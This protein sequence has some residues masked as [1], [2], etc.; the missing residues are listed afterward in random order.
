V[1]LLQEKNKN[2]LFQY[3]NASK[4]IL[5][6]KKKIQKGVTSNSKIIDFFFLDEQNAN[7]TTMVNKDLYLW[8]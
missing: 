2:T 1:R 4:D 7:Y 6:K 5:L 8:V 3:L